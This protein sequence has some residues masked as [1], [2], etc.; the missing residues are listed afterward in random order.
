MTSD[1]FQ[2]TTV[3]DVPS[4]AIRQAVADRG[5]A[6]VRG[7][8]DRAELRAIMDRFRSRFDA[9]LDQRHDPRDSDAA[10]RNFQK[11]QIGANS[12]VNSRRT[13][14]RFMRVFYN[15]VFADDVHG[16]RA[17]FVTLA[18]FRNRLYD[19]PLDYAV[20]G[21]DD[22]FWT[23]ARIQQYPS[24]GGFMVPHRDQYAQ[25]ATTERGLDYFQVLLLL[26]EKGVDFHEGGAYVD[27]GDDRLYYEGGAHIGDVVVYDGRTVH[28]V[29]DIDP[30]EPLDLQRLTGRL[31]GVASLFRLL[32]PG[33]E[34]YAEMARSARGK[35]GD[36]ESG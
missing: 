23:A 31:V 30:M 11:L 3:D 9:R 2:I 15:P 8:F 33:G 36:G 19:L 27:V 13:L 10:R 20:H 28:G 25:V 22:G 24:G 17:S 4:D 6:M 14:G 35:F 29:A 5:F 12:G 26:S 7:L 18:R 32:T 16:L 21:T 1:P 34:D